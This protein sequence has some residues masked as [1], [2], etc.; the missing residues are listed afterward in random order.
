MWHS[1]AL[2]PDL[3]DIVSVNKD[4]AQLESCWPR[5]KPDKK[6]EVLLLVR[7]GDGTTSRLST[8]RQS[9]V[10]I[11]QLCKQIKKLYN[12]LMILVQVV[13]YNGS[14]ILPPQQCQP[15]LA[16][17]TGAALLG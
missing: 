5:A 2:Q 7:V 13:S 1:K 16:R 12:V 6:D 9:Q 15:W 3:A 8:Y 14:R 11:P 17:H 4:T 10:K